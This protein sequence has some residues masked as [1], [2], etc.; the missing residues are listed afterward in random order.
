MLNFGALSSLYHKREMREESGTGE[1]GGM[2]TSGGLRSKLVIFH[3]LQDLWSF[4]PYI[5]GIKNS[6]K[7]KYIDRRAK[8]RDSYR[9]IASESHCRDSKH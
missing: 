2:F 8:S 1:G 6:L 7:R 3:S 4:L 5:Q 9:R